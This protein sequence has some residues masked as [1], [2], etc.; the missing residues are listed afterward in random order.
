MS[1][2]RLAVV[3]L[4]VVAGCVGLG[5]EGSD[6]NTVAPQIDGTPTPTTSPTPTPAYP[7]GVFADSTDAF[8][9]A[10]GHRSVVTAHNT[11]IRYSRTVRRPNGTLLSS[12]RLRAATE[13]DRLLIRIGG[14]VTGSVRPELGR[15][16]RTIWSN[17]SVV[18]TRQ[19]S[20]DGTT[21]YRFTPFPP[22]I[23]YSPLTTGTTAI[24][25]ALVRQNL[26]V[27]SSRDTRRGTRVVLAGGVRRPVDGLGETALNGTIRAAIRGDG[28]V[29]RFEVRYYTRLE[30][31]LAIVTVR[32]RT[33]ETEDTRVRRPAWVAT[34]INE[35]DGGYPGEYGSVTPGRA[36]SGSE[37]GQL[38]Q[39]NLW[40]SRPAR[41][42]R[43]PREPG[44]TA[45]P[46]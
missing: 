20:T 13:G 18:V 4:V 5:G 45:D 41:G 35:S 22:G 33:V 1:R 34:G 9:V 8:E 36:A 26:S 14:R 23:A 28:L 46:V 42:D 10:R 7:R 2:L 12:Y 37:F 39:F 16:N 29:E 11:T 38:G 19:V 40:A 3:L 31:E 6:R 21:D 15:G 17:G 24:H 43:T 25:S 27:V 32:Y 30:G 44:R